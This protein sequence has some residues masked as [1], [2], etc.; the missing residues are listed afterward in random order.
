MSS[1]LTPDE[2][3]ATRFGLT[4]PELVHVHTGYRGT[5]TSLLR[6]EVRSVYLRRYADHWQHRPAQV[7]FELRWLN[8]LVQQ[9]QRVPT[10]VRTIEGEAAVVDGGLPVAVFTPVPGAPRYPLTPSEA[11]TLGVAL[12]DL[13][14]APA[15]SPGPEV[16]RYD[17]DTL[18]EAPL[19]FGLQFLQGADAEAWARLGAEWRAAV[20]AIPINETTFG[21][22]HADLHQW[23]VMWDGPVP[24][25]LDFA[26]CGIGYRLYDLA[27]F[28]WPRRDD[29]AAD[30]AVA[31]M[32]DAFVEGYRSRRP[33]C[34]EEEAALGVVVRLRDVW[35]MRDFAEWDEK[36]DA[37]RDVP[38]YLARFQ[39]FPTA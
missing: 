33:L 20:A 8:L 14:R 15:P 12:A 19:S 31:A 13:H 3:L 4:D 1:G 39:A 10:V 35:E 29:T 11:A 23:N 2:K 21:A 25:L 7:T 30:P 18:L 22:V 37:A 16:F 38:G 24:Y 9:G 32:C 34:A 26:L 27:G 17:L 36:F 5:R 6:D 28:L